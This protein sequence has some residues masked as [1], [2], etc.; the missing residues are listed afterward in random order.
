MRA[1]SHRRDLQTNVAGPYKV[2]EVC[3]ETLQPCRKLRSAD[4]V[5]ILF[6]CP[7]LQRNHS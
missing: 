3:A 6:I 5:V 1:P 4:G 2:S 7:V